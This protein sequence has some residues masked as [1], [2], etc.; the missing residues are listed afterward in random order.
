MD[1]PAHESTLGL[2]LRRVRAG[3]FRVLEVRHDAGERLLPHRHAHPSLCCVLD[4]GFHE[5]ID[6]TCFRARPASLLVEPAGRPHHSRF[7]RRPTRSLILEVVDDELAARLSRHGSPIG[8]PSLL[9]SPDLARL[10]DRLERELRL[11]DRASELAIEGL[12]LE[13]LA[14]SARLSGQERHTPP[15]WLERAADT[16]RS[17]CLEDVTTRELAA[18]AGVHPAH[19]TRSFRRYFG[20]TPRDRLRSLRLDWCAAHL[21]ASDE[22]VAE[23]ATRTGFCDSSHL[24]RH[25]R[26]RFGCSPAAYRRRYAVVRRGV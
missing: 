16:L 4:G 24:A 7:G 14:E 22:S 15:A 6:G 2:P 21:A 3:G 20:E 17:R 23:L 19:F 11:A 9:C 8:K 12:A 25:F 10:G 18:D 5:W 1:A 13:L 26:R